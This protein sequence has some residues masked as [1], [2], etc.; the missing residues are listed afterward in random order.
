MMQRFA[1][2]LY[3]GPKDKQIVTPNSWLH[4][5]TISR[6]LKEADKGSPAYVHLAGK[7][8]RISG[9]ETHPFL[10]HKDLCIPS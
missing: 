10:P 3:V 2:K 1:Y 4:P 6:G 8:P 5:Q 9:S 7:Q